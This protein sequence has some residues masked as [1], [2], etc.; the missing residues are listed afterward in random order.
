[1]DVLACVRLRR[2]RDPTFAA[3]SVVRSG[4]P[5]FRRQRLAIA[6]DTSRSMTLAYRVQD[7]SNSSTIPK[8]RWEQQ[9]PRCSINR[10]QRRWKSLDD[11]LNVALI[12]MTWQAR[13]SAKGFGQ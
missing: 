12:V 3:S 11:N 6:I 7:N 8:K 9:R 10:S 5:A 13:V 4:Q 2:S 1:M